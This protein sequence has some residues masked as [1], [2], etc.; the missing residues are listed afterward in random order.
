MKKFLIHRAIDT[1]R[2]IIIPKGLTHVEIYE[3]VYHDEALVSLFRTVE[4]I[5]FDNKGEPI[6][7]LEDDVEIDKRVTDEFLNF[8]V[9]EFKNSKYDF[10]Q[11]GITNLIPMYKKYV[12]S[13]KDI[14]LWDLYHSVGSHGVLYMPHF[15]KKIKNQKPCHI[16]YFLSKYNSV[17]T[18]PFLVNQ[19]NLN[20]STVSGYTHQKDRCMEAENKLKKYIEN[21]SNSI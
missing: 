2:N 14:D 6:L 7:I 20:T 3:P 4:K 9:K 10:V 11:L 5:L 19:K 17:L 18:L 21:D 15:Y 12:G 1:D 8:L 16:D 13:Y